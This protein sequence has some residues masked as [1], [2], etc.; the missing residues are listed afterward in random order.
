M[1]HGV[2]KT[3]LTLFLFSLGMLTLSAPV[4]AGPKD[5][6]T[7]AQSVRIPPPNDGKAPRTCQS[8]RTMGGFAG[9]KSY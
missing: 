2:M 9:C 7:K 4:Q 6:A 3:L 8:G 5:G 1:Y